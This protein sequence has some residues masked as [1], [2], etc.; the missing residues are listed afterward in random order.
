MQL[1]RRSCSIIVPVLGTFSILKG[2]KDPV[3]L[4][5][6]KMS[7]SRMGSQRDLKESRTGWVVVTRRMG[8]RGCDSRVG[9]CWFD[10]PVI[11]LRDVGRG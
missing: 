5:S 6:T 1:W 11:R 8:R 10:C 9:M 4:N 7:K 2:M 3:A